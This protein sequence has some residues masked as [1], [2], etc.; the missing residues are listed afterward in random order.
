MGRS[1]SAAAAQRPEG[2]EDRTKIRALVC[3]ALYHP[4]PLLGVAEHRGDVQQRGAQTTAEDMDHDRLYVWGL[5]TTGARCGL[6]L[7]CGMA[8]CVGGEYAV[9][10]EC[11][12]YMWPHLVEGPSRSRGRVPPS[13]A[14][15]AARSVGGE[16][17]LLHVPIGEAVLESAGLRGQALG[18]GL[19]GDVGV[20]EMAQGVPLNAVH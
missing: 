6:M 4:D 17:V 15:E 19:L 7:C 20:S 5:R 10:E 14:V 12:L 3:E 18:E 2:Q 9:W 8:I 11:S 13:E 16:H 1:C